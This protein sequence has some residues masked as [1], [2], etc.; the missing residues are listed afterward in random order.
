MSRLIF[1][2]CILIFTMFATSCRIA[3]VD[4]ETMNAQNSYADFEGVSVEV[5]EPAPGF[6]L[7]AGDNKT[8]SLKDYKNKNAVMLLF[9]RG[10]WCPY[11]MDQL[12]NYQRLL[13]ELE[14][15]DIQLIAI[16]P[17]NLTAMKNTQ[18]KFGQSYIFLSDNDLK[19]TH[20]YGIGNASSLPHPSLFL[21]NKSGVLEWYYASSDHNT[22]PTA[23]QVE[24]IIQ[25]I[26]V[27]K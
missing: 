8:I 6:S 9:Y 4:P 16:S 3:P 26:F 22:R 5:G 13:P 15:Y 18:R 2:A 19:V 25:Q 24:K 17:D 20:Q 7:P 12:D 11:C 1:A 10:D 21:I 27:N 14:K 23:S